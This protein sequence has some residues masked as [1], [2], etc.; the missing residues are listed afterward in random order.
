VVYIGGTTDF[1]NYIHIICDS[2]LIT[3]S[4][5]RIGFLFTSIFTLLYVIN[6][7]WVARNCFVDCFMPIAHQKSKTALDSVSHFRFSQLKTICFYKVYTIRQN[8]N[9]LSS[10]HLMNWFDLHVVFNKIWNRIIKKTKYV[11]L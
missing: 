8:K 5:F 7:S 1:M 3:R 2:M 10:C 4:I 9:Q 6:L 11:K